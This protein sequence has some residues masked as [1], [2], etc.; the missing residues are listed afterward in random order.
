MLIAKREERNNKLTPHSNSI[1]TPDHKSRETF[2]NDVNDTYH[3]IKTRVAEIAKESAS[4]EAGVE[5]IQ[6]HAVDPNTRIHITIPP[7]QSSEPEAIHARQIFESFSPELQ[8]ALESESL[9]EVNKVLGKMS[10]PEAEEILDKFS[11]GSIL[12][13][14]EGVVD[15]TT[16]EGKKQFEEI[17]AEGKREKETETVEEVGEPG[18]GVD[19]LD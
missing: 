2:L 13:I 4:K 18:E 17:E 19:E 6:L 16:E 12:S 8:K 1:T 7:A 10:V 11:E 15:T 3:R 14:Q 9:D 5:Q